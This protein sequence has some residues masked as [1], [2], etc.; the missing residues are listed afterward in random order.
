MTRKRNTDGDDRRPRRDS[1]P[2]A[3]PPVVPPPKPPP[4]DRH[5]RTPRNCETIGGPGVKPAKG[6]RVVG[7]M[8]CCSLTDEVFTEIIGHVRAGNFRIVAAKAAGVLP[9]TLWKWIET[10][11]E[12]LADY[13][14]GKRQ[15][16]PLQGQLVIELDRAEGKCF[17][18][19][20]ALILSGGGECAE[21]EGAGRGEEDEACHACKGLG[22]MMADIDDRKLRFAWLQ[23]R[24]AREWSPPTAGVDD[25]TGA[26][27][28]IDVS[29]LLIARL[30]ALKDA[31]G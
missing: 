30:Q 29:E 27:K 23:R 2:P 25:E 15:D 13:L 18:E 28:Q 5:D 7:N 11:R 8:P 26:P 3:A 24:F 31:D 1:F 9:A 6:S 16:V 19:H 17:I 14:D 12:Q 22:A 10:G 20:N 21:C 4:K